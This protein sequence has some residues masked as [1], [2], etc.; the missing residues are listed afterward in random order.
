ML[1]KLLLA[2]L[3][4]LGMIGVAPAAEPQLRPDHPTEYVVQRGDTLWDIAGRFLTYPWQWPE[5]WRANPEVK[6]PHLIYPG[7][8]LVLS[9]V[10]GRPVV[11]VIPGEVH[12]GGRRFKRSPSV[13]EQ[14]NVEPIRVIPLEAIS[15]FLERPR[16]LSAQEARDAPYVVSSQD[17]TLIAGPGNRIYARGLGEVQPGQRLVIVRTGVTYH[18]YEPNLRLPDVGEVLGHEALYVGD[19]LVTRAGDPAT[20]LVTGGVREILVGDR[21]LPEEK[22]QFPEFIPHP[23][24]NEIE[25]RVIAL[26]DGVSQAGQYQIVVVDHG[27]ETGLEPGNVLTVYEAGARVL[28]PIATTR[29]QQQIERIEFQRADQSGAEQ[30]VEN[31]VNDIIANKRA[32]DRALGQDRIQREVEVR[33]PDEPTGTAMVFRVFPRVSYAIVLDIERP[34]RLHDALRS[35]SVD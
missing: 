23:P 25:G 35:P 31:F 6:N 1:N 7:D 34:V 12:L 8:R 27:S 5:I 32:L 22:Q 14:P 21:L 15:P 17:Q 4:F 30:V 13:R 19:A 3:G 9:Y 33:L 11:T 18:A 2:A 24:S 16:V 10:D 29:G 26:V 20:L 28:D